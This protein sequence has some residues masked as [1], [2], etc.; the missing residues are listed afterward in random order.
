MPGC[1]CGISKSLSTVAS[2]L[3][4]VAVGV[5]GYNYATTGCPLGVNWC[6]TDQASAGMVAPDH[7]HSRGMRMGP[8]CCAGGE[9][10]AEVAKPACCGGDDCTAECKAACGAAASEKPAD[11]ATEAAPGTSDAPAKSDAPADVEPAVGG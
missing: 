8:E 4:L 5:G 1:A 11:S 7:S 10:K 2:V 9:T 6:E 3:G